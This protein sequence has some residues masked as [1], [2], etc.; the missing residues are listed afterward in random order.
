MK[1]KFNII[2][3]SLI[4]A[5]TVATIG[6]KISQPESKFDES[7]KPV[8]TAPVAPHFEY[9]GAEGPANWSL[10]ADQY[11]E[12][13]S[14]VQT[15]ID[16]KSTEAVTALLPE[17]K[18]DYLPQMYKVSDNGHTIVFTPTANNYIT[19]NG[20]KS[21]LLQFHYHI[22]S[23]HE[24]DDKQYKMEIHFVNKSEDGNLTV[25][26]V[27][28]EPGQANPEFDKLTQAVSKVLPHDAV[29]HVATSVDSDK[30]LDIKKLLPT[31]TKLFNYTGSLTTP[32]CTAGVNWLLFSTPITLGENQ[33]APFAKR[34]DNNAR[35]IQP[36]NGRI[37]Y[38]NK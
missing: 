14:K 3:I 15:P 24:I 36:T 28:I 25:L 23:E 30:F 7:P 6:Y 31:N 22:P 37:I 4:L 17:I 19:V 10:L 32:P 35:P 21:T 8:A 5:I 29:N 20:K 27:F 33:I 2:V 18:L 26:G 11:K 1:D 34:Y 13:A 12:C 38:S 9:S 16:I